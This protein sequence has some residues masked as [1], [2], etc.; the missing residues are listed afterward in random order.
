MEVNAALA[1][2]F[3]ELCSVAAG[4]L[5]SLLYPLLQC[6]KKRGWAEFAPEPK[7]VWMPKLEG[8]TK[9]LSTDGG[10]GEITECLVPS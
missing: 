3:P 7:Q 4:A 10:E 5:G 8:R 2:M 9:L 6:A 1:P